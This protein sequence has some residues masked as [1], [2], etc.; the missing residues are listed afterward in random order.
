MNILIASSEAVPFVKTGGLGDIVGAMTGELA[1]RNHRVK[2]V[3]P[4]YSSIDRSTFKLRKTIELMNVEMGNTTLS[5]RVW[6]LDD[7]NPFDVYFIEYKHYFFRPDLYGENNDAY[8]DN[9]KRFSFFSKAVLDL[10]IQ[11]DFKPDV[12]HVNDWQTAVIP[13]YLKTWNWGSR[14][15][16]HTASVLTIHNLGYQGLANLSI[17]NFIGLNWMQVREEEFESLGSLNLL[18]GGIFYADQITTVSPTYATEILSEPGGWG[19]STYLSRRKNDIT[20]IL[21][22]VDI[23]E[24]NPGTDPTIPAN[25]SRK[26][27]SGK[28]VC[29]SELQSAFSL[30]V[31]KDIPIFAY[32]GRFADQKGLSMLKDC[33]DTILSWELQFIVLGSGDPTYSELFGNLP[34][35]YPDKVATYIGFQSDLAH[36]VEAGADFFVMP[37]VYEP[38]GLNQMYSMIYGTLPIVRGTGG[39]VDTVDNFDEKNSKGTGFV[40]NDI[41]GKALE[42]TIGWAL[43]TWYNEKESYLAMQQRGM[44]KD[45]SWSKALSA[46]EAVYQKAHDRRSHWY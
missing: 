21:N 10:T 24:W 3:L 46:Y 23:S 7:E 38:C 1:T 5:C 26:D 31:N 34:K 39:L 13:Y 4:L 14:F 40:F 41:A 33:L 17:S 2:L 18:K 16:D 15:F 22:G 6:Q 29:K 28:A 44:E 36:Q 42:N 32:I 25:F 11:L 30:P 35:Y 8:L 45:F 37:S 19:L 9:G 12:V 20:G 43:S 27:L